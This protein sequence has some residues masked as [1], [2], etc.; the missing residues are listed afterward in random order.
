MRGILIHILLF[1]EGGRES[2][3]HSRGT[4]Y[5]FWLYA[6]SR[7][8]TKDFNL[9]KKTIEINYLGAVSMLERVVGKFEEQNNGFV[10]AISSVAGD[11]GRKSNYIYGSSKGALTRYLEGLQ[12]R[13]S[14]TKV[15]VP[16]C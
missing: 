14:S 8:S 16:Y 12:H 1:G 10:I 7:R 3:Q 6:R 9:I 13:L 2:M 11:R 4:G 15:R 5:L